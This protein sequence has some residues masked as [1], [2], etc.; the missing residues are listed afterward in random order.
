M[1]RVTFDFGNKGDN[2][3]VSTYSSLE[4]IQGWIENGIK[5]NQLIDGAGSHKLVSKDDSE[6]GWIKYKILLDGTNELNV[7]VRY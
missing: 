5:T 1:A 6:I 3:T 4:R 2:E 7:T